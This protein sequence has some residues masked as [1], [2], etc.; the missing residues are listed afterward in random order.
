MEVVFQTRFS[1]F[2]VSGWQSATSQSEEMLFDP[3]RLNKRFDLFERIALAGLRDQTDDDF[4]LSVL[5][6]TNLPQNTK[7]GWKSC[8]MTPWGQSALI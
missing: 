3:E 5:S 7:P 4:K 1:F 8:V 2:G 6:S